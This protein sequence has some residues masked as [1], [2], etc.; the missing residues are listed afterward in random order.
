MDAPDTVAANCWDAP[1]PTVAVAGETDTDTPLT[2]VITAWADFNGS[3]VL[4]AFTMTAGLDGGTA[5]AA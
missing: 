2:T 5:G 1:T 4:T 3:A